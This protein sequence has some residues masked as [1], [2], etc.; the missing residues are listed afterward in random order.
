MARQVNLDDYDPELVDTVRVWV[1][2]CGE[3]I[4]IDARNIQHLR[5]GL[6]NLAVRADELYPELESGGRPMLSVEDLGAF[7]LPLGVAETYVMVTGTVLFNG[8]D[9]PLIAGERLEQALDTIRGTL[10]AREVDE[11]RKAP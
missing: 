5:H 2:F 10:L 8:A 6:R 1:E 9:G 7:P 4:S 11:R 3:L